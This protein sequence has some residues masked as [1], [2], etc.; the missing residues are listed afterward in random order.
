MKRPS[1]ETVLAF[2]KTIADSNITVLIRESKGQ[3]IFAACGQ[4]KARYGEKTR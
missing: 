3:D 4:L 2:Q 1:E